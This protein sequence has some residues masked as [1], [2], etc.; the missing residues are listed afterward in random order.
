MT[1]LHI[2]HF[3]STPF[4]VPP[5]TYGGAER[6]VYWLAR[7]QARRGHT[8]SVIAHPDSQV[9]KLHPPIRLIPAYKARRVAELLPK[10]CDVVHLH[11]LPDD[12]AELP[13]PYV[14]TE[15]A[16]RGDDAFLPVNTAFVSDSHARR[17]GRG[18]F[19][20]NG[21]P[22][23]EYRYSEDKDR[24]LLFLS[25]MEA[26][27]KNVCTAIDLAMD[28]DVPLLMSG[29]VS[30]WRR[31]ELRGDWCRHPLKYL[32]LV[33]RIGYVGGERKLDLLARAPL[34]FHAVNWHEPQGL[35]VLEAHA[36]GTPV[37]STPNGALPE[38]VEDGV[39][40]WM[41]RSYGEA[42]EATR[43]ALAMPPAE[44]AAWARR[45]RERVTSVE[46]MADGYHRLYERVI[47]GEALSHAGEVRPRSEPPVVEVLKGR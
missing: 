12:H 34:L 27:A 22:L 18:C 23:E 41:V 2:V 17:H 8:V 40:G 24:H 36:S 7:E 25:R 15:H 10:D 38:F 21:V 29:K 31:A 13:Q 44:R 19:V 4:P 43:R 20:P 33:R 26:K 30:P 1:P 37:L 39:N 32:R 46:S 28:L 6:I 3:A 16:N 47:A 35:V 42:L 5:P 45:C 14:M 9:Q 11:R